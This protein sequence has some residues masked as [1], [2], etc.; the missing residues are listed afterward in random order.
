MSEVSAVL[1]AAQRSL[2]D[3]PSPAAESRA[4]LQAAW[5]VTG[6]QL[7]RA[8]LMGDAVPAPVQE[9]MRASV[10]LRATGVP[11]Q[12][13][14]GTAPFR[15]LEL[16][17]GPGVFIP[18]PET[19]VLVDEVI[20]HTAGRPDLKPPHILDL[21]SGTGA[22]GLALA[23]EINGS[24]VAAVELESAALTWAAR[25]ADALAPEVSA[26][27]S[28]YAVH[29]ADAT[30]PAAVALIVDAGLGGRVD[31]VASNP[32]Y[33]VNDG[34]TVDPAVL[35]HD[36]HTA[37]WGGGLEGLDIPTAIVVTAAHVLA[38]GGFFI[39]EH[40]RT[41]GAALRSALRSAGFDDVRT[42]ADYTGE[43]RF[44]MGQRTGSGH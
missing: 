2:A 44:T 20:A 14:V 29:Q 7:N 19:E 13:V 34:T 11:L 3:S 8:R 41:Q 36:P 43:E 1:A 18:R 15:N 23:T 24:C 37:L 27:G 42:R 10:A 22:I 38:P 17:V 35:N 6:A 21:C 9:V 30:D 4:L 33:V 25:A 16:P 32:P 26:A 12:H 39:I 5:G 28:N 40:A 31:V